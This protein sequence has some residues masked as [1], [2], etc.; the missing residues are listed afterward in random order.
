MT[1]LNITLKYL[2]ICYSCGQ[3]SQNNFWSPIFFRYFREAY[4]NVTLK[5]TSLLCILKKMP[6]YNF[7][8]YDT[9]PIWVSALIPSGHD[10]FYFLINCEF[11][12]PVNSPEDKNYKEFNWINISIVLK[13]RMEPYREEI[14]KCCLR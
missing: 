2:F 10:R 8:F 1:Y 11:V 5:K 3:I 12:P 7:H 6:I 14:E 4:K 9:L 13:D